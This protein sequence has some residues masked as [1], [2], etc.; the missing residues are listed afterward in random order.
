LRRGVQ[1]DTDGAEV[2]TTGARA[3]WSHRID[4]VS[5]I[6]VD[7][8]FASIE[9]LDADSTVRES[10]VSASYSRLITE[11]WSAAIGL[12]QTLRDDDRASGS[13]VSRSVFVSLG[14]SFDT[15]F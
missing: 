3:G 5:G 11:D 7:F 8:G 13:A 10:Q 15:S 4:R 2:L 6:A 14:R 9:D 12:G 1:D